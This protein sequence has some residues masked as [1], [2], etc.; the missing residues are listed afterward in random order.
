MTSTG[1]KVEGTK[2]S[3]FNIKEA[4]NADRIEMALK[5]IKNKK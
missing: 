2:F 4:R 5:A 3:K 1:K